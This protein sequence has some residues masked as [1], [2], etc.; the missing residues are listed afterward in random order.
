[1]ANAILK[2]LGK[3]SSLCSL[4]VSSDVP[5]FKVRVFASDFEFSIGI[6]EHK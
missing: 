2:I 3:F 4:C 5:A 6:N 1:M